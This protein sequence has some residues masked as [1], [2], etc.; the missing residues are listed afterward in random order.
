MDRGQQVTH[1]S[2]A[3]AIE[4]RKGQNCALATELITIA[5]RWTHAPG[6]DADLSALLLSDGRVRGDDDFVFYNHALSTDQA[7]EHLGKQHSPPWIHDRIR[8]DL[9]S[10][11]PGLDAVAITLSLYSPGQ[12]LADLGPVTIAITEPNG[13][14]V[15]TF[16]IADMTVETA[17][18]TVEL[19]R[20]SGAWKLRAVGQGYHDGLAG[21]ARDF[22][23]TVDEDHTLEPAPP[24]TEPV[25]DW[26]HPPVPAGYEL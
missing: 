11:D 26:T 13:A 9:R 6:L 2:G 20:R 23:V 24:A 15:A 3:C 10:L 14:T 25:V 4:L 17:A 18:V 7:I 12:R 1:S 8:A 19:Y 22:G 21:L 5:C 16:T